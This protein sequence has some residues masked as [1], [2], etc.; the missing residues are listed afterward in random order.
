MLQSKSTAVTD[1][2]LGAEDPTAAGPET[3]QA[4]P[5]PAAR[6]AS[7]ATTLLRACDITPTTARRAG[8]LR[9]RYGVL[10]ARTRTRTTA[11]GGTWPA[12]AASAPAGKSKTAIIIWIG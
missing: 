10:V 9:E 12:V 3:A 2:A 6:A 4:A 1:A 8:A 5:V 11:N 7:P